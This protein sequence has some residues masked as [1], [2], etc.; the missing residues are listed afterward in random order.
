M[1]EL[2]LSQA[3]VK[4]NSV[5]ENQNPGAT[6]VKFSSETIESLASIRRQISSLESH[7]LESSFRTKISNLE[8]KFAILEAA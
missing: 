6:F 8:Y 1:N 2:L 4:A 5:A 7:S 3:K